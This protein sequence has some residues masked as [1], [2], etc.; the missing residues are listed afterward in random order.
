MKHALALGIF[1]TLVFYSPIAKGQDNPGRTEP[2]PTDV[3][4][5]KQVAIELGKLRQ[6]TAA[7]KA[8]VRHALDALREAF[9]TA[10][11][12]TDMEEI[13]RGGNKASAA[14]DA[15]EEVIPNGALKGTLISC[16]K[17]LGHSYFLRLVDSGGMDANEPQVAALLEEI[18]IRYQLAR[19]PKYERP[20]KVLDFAEFHLTIAKEISFRAGII[21]K[22]PE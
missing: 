18:M 8:K 13:A 17:A 4:S 12:S 9:L 22:R 16:K 15:A 7:N 2:K 5:E 1:F 6:M 21:S 11:V 19:I 14:V 10:S 3:L 20:A